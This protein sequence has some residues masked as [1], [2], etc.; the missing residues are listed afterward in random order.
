MKYTT[1]MLSAGLAVALILALGA[2]SASAQPPSGS[3]PV[4][5]VVHTSGGSGD[6]GHFILTGGRHRGRSHRAFRGF[7]SSLFLGYPGYSYYGTYIPEYSPN[8]STTCVWNG[9]EYKCYNFLDE[10]LL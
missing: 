1:I 8:P 2:A 6:A 7:R 10:P 5:A 9:Y 3:F 4:A